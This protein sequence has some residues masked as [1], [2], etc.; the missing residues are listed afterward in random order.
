MDVKLVSPEFI[1][2][3]AHEFDAGADLRANID[4]P[5]VIPP[6]HRALIPT[7]VFAD[8]SPVQTGILKDRSGLAWNH[9]IHILGGVLDPGFR[10]EI[11]VVLLNTDP[12][13]EFV[14]RPKER[15]AQM[16]VVHAQCVPFNEVD[17]ISQTPRGASG[18]GDS[19]TE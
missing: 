5:I 13:T 1:P 12:K 3:R 19:G 16:I 9:G 14:V 18:F 7:G 11:K 8:F 10:G 2:V 15:I 4:A 6:G 17:E